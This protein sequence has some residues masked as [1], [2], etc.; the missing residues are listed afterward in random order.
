MP[1]N[2]DRFSI[3]IDIITNKSK[4][5]LELV[6]NSIINDSVFSSYHEVKDRQ[7]K[8]G[9]SK[10]HYVFSFAPTANKNGT[11]IL[12][13]LFEDNPYK[14]ITRAEIRNSFL[15]T[16]EPW[17]TVNIPSIDSILGDK[18]TAFAPNTI[19]VPYWLGNPEIPD[20]RIE[21]IKQLHDNSILI[22]HSSDL[23]E[24][25]SVFLTIA[26]NQLLYRSINGTIEDVIAD[27]FS[28]ALII[29][30]RGRNSV[31]ADISKF[32]DIQNGL[33]MFGEYLITGSFKIEDAICASAKVAFITQGFIHDEQKNYLLYN[34]TLNLEN[35]NIRNVEY[36]FL[37]R[38]K[39]TNKPAFYYWYCCLELMNLID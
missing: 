29:A 26:K 22:D 3:D 28:I 23:Q 10:A 7:N 20:K 15:D 24:V 14:T 2:S 11:I 1:V 18:L 21:I 19:G 37:N 39:K 32:E 25:K 4:A 36:N 35:L 12:D 33:K 6:L 5:E 31:E 38:L 8:G 34:S 17:L 30:K 9:I 27:I 16:S 13:V